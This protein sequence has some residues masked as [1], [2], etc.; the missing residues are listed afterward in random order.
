MFALPNPKR[1]TL[2]SPPP[3]PVRA[4]QLQLIDAARQE[5][6]E[7]PPRRKR[8]ATVGGR[9][10]QKIGGHRKSTAHNDSSD[11]EAF[12]VDNNF[13][14]FADNDQDGE[15]FWDDDNLQLFTD[16]DQDGEA[17]EYQEEGYSV[18]VDAI[19][20]EECALYQLTKSLFIVNGWDCKA[21]AATVSS[22]ITMI[23]IH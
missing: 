17:T 12:W 18:F 23:S 15:A 3:S 13:E 5:T 4:I 21:A 22:V 16:N 11:G 14:T 7:T 8:S 1:I 2:D 6:T 19:L 9:K 20:A 10:R